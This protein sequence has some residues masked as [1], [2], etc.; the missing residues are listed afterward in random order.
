[1]IFFYVFNKKLAFILSFAIIQPF[2]KKLVT[3]TKEDFYMKKQVIFQSNENSN[4]FHQLIEDKNEKKLIELISGY[5]YSSYE[6]LKNSEEYKNSQFVFQNKE[7][8]YLTFEEFIQVNYD[9]ILEKSYD[10]NSLDFDD[11]IRGY[12]FSLP[13]KI[14]EDS[15]FFI[16]ASIGTWRGKYSSSKICKGFKDTILTC[17]GSTDEQTVYFGKHGSLNITGH[18]HDGTNHFQIFLIKDGLEDSK[19]LERLTNKLYSQEE[20]TIPKN[21]LKSNLKKFLDY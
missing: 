5:D 13:S 12:S 18:H 6:K 4:Y 7:N 8:E 21:I 17:F 20:Y 10:L 15:Y 3:P 19:T 9:E 11:F 2:Q 1:M 16:L 14:L